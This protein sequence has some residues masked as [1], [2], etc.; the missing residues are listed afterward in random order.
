MNRIVVGIG[1]LLSGLLKRQRNDSGNNTVFH[2]KQRSLF[3][4]DALHRL[5]CP[6]KI[7]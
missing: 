3:I 7:P 1:Q 6:V 2:E 5:S 4:P